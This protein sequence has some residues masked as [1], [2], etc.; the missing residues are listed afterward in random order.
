MSTLVPFRGRHF[1]AGRVVWLALFGSAMWL[2]AG[3][4]DPDWRSWQREQGLTDSNVDF[5]SRDATGAVWAVHGD[6]PAITRFDGRKFTK[7]PAP[8]I[9]NR[10]DSVDGENGWTD[11]Q[12]GLRHLQDGKW[13]F[14]PE[15][16]NGPQGLDYF[17]LRYFRA[18]D[19]GDSRVL[20]LFPERLAEFS[21]VTGRMETLPLPA[22]SDLGPLITFERA[23]DGTIWVVG[24]RGAARFRYKRGARIPADWQ[25]YSL[26]NF[27]IRD[28]RHPVAGL[29]G[30]LCVSGVLS[31]TARRV[32]LWLHDGKWELLARQE[33]PGQPL[34]AWRDGS[35]TFWLADGDLL[36]K[37]PGTD[38]GA[39]WQQV[40]QQS[41][42]LGGRLKEVVVN[43][44]GTFFLATSRGLA[45]HVN[46]TWRTYDGVRDS[47]GKAIQLREHVGAL[48]ADRR[49]R[50]WFLTERSLLRLYRDQW[51]EYSLPEAM[52]YKTDANC[53]Q[54]LGELPDGR[55]LIQMQAGNL[56]AFDPDTLQ[57]AKVAAPPGY[58][59]RMFYRR[60]DGSFLLEMLAQAPG[61]PDALAV[62]RGTSITEV[63][64][65]HDKWGMV[66]TRAFLEDAQGVVWLGGL[67]GLIRFDHDRVERL[68]WVPF[69]Q[70]AQTAGV[71]SLFAEPDARLLV[72]AR[73]GLYKWNGHDVELANDRIQIVRQ[74]IRSRSGTLWVASSN[75][76]F[77]SFGRA[78]PEDDLAGEWVS[79]DAWDGLPTSAVYSVGEDWQGRI[80]VGTNKGPAV[81]LPNT[82]LDPPEAAIRADQNSD[83]AAPSGQF[84]VIF[85]GRDKWDLTPADM[86]RFSY[87]LDGGKWSPFTGNTTTTFN[88]LPIGKHRFEVIAMDREGNIGVEPAR[89]DFSVVPPWYRAR[90]FLLLAVAALTTIGCL[91]GLAIRHVRQLE[92]LRRAAEAASHAKSE[93]LANM[94]HEIRTPMNGVL[95]MTQVVLDSDLNAEQR[96]CL[97]VVK[98]SA[99]SLLSII[100]DVLDFSKIEAGKLDLEPMEFNLRDELA[101]ICRALAGWAH[102]KG[103]Q[104]VCSVQPDVA[105]A[106]VGDPARLRQV[107]TNLLANAIKFTA[108]GEVSLEVRDAVEQ[109]RGM[110]HFTVRDTG[111]GIP[112]EKHQAIFQAFTQ[113]D[114]STT[115][116]F[117]GSGLGLTIS[118]RLVRMMGGRIW[119]E[120]EPGVGSQFHF[121]AQL[122]TGGQPTTRPA[123]A[124]ASEPAGLPGESNRQGT[125]ADSGPSG[126]AVAPRPALA[127]LVAE[128][129]PIN[130]KVARRLLE[131]RGHSVEVVA[132]GT[133][134]VR[135]WERRIF[136]VIFMD[137][138]MPEMD[139]YEAT[140]EIRRNERN[141]GRHQTIIAMTAHAMKG[142]RERCLESGMDGYLPKPIRVS[143]LAAVLE[144]WG[145]SVPAGNSAAD[146]SVEARRASQEGESAAM[147]TRPR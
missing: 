124:V 66:T 83:E 11:D 44:D 96:E 58:I 87:R 82:D 73:T 61:Q 132:S 8:V 146:L 110:L 29:N 21:A 62:L 51:D 33:L 59:P 67:Q 107:L 30:E 85:S 2:P 94:S 99:E 52:R 112:R 18:L 102:Q 6:M 71:F 20:L 24:E 141:T 115:R 16:T 10:F 32:A 138:Q 26:R 88:R 97:E 7:L 123:M 46:P 34:F 77:R 80:W 133:E 126:S 65:I 15:I 38:P 48:M 119:V 140:A 3:I 37:R 86:L 137:V 135:A 98:S 136:D 121:T 23:P 103:L 129:N 79:S 89:L 75:G 117:G 127:I 142:D 69:N 145:A 108:A 106:V 45:L 93:F 95:G 31:G 111:V 109:N 12:Y 118:A 22:G 134:A 92:H 74:L 84:S 35:G 28:I 17:L 101:G 116:K 36:R 19:L 122:E 125:A 100:N 49:E 60:A 14:F 5:L 54:V 90:T 41:E 72:G 50:M 9:Y 63:R 4:R 13:Q 53:A 147:G 76:V 120:S 68:E 143:E 130:Q 64:S 42:V 139:G 105:E 81:F 27:P 55:I 78:R 144:R 56:V 91:I 57:F 131:G 43:P 40:D 25:E 114:A 70:K 39:K 104:L 47:Q 1:F 113:A 128:D